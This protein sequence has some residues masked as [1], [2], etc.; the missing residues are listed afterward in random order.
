M[1]T[2]FHEILAWFVATATLAVAGFF[3]VSA[4]VE[5]TTN[6]GYELHLRLIRF[7]GG[8]AVRAYEHGGE[9]ELA[10]LLGRIRSAYDFHAVLTDR[11][12]HPLSGP[13]DDF[14]SLIDCARRRRVFA[15]FT[16]RALVLAHPVDGEHWF[17]LLLPASTSASGRAC[18]A[19]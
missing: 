7:H 15:D 8:E 3:A 6:R 1:K 12:G 11:E 17:F 5:S 4:L 16:R 14:A 10:A 19:T 18:A 13:P 2:L 9:E